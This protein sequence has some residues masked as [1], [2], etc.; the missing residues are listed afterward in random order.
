M[1]KGNGHPYSWS[2]I[3]NNYDVNRTE[4]CPFPVIPEYLRLEDWPDAMISEAKIDGIYCTSVLDAFSISK[5]SYIGNVY[6]E[7]ADIPTTCDGIII[8]RDDS[9]NHFKF[10]KRFLN[11]DIPVL[12]DKPIATNLNDFRKLEKYENLIFS[13]TS[14]IYSDAWASFKTFFTENKSKIKKIIFETPNSWTRYGV[15]I[16]EPLLFLVSDKLSLLQSNLI[17]NS[18]SNG[19]SVNVD[20]VLFKLYSTDK[21]GINVKF[22][23]YKNNGEKIIFAVNDVFNSFKGLLLDFVNFVQGYP[24]KFSGGKDHYKLLVS[25]IDF[26][27]YR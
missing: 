17:R 20:G 14:C 9:E 18:V 19:F 16:V 24:V 23:I 3:F 7:L 6:Q 27:N 11:L 10:S 4:E 26:G 2:A 21:P 12:L 25:L 5:F 15:H 13:H 22:I 1:S 8:A